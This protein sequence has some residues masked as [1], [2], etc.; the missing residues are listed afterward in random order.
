[1]TFSEVKQQILNLGFETAED[2]E[3]E[4]TILTDALNLAMRQITNLFP[5]IGSYAIRQEPVAAGEP[6]YLRYDF[7]E[8]TR[9]AD[10]TAVF[11][12]FLELVTEDGEYKKTR[13]FTVEQRHVLVLDGLKKING[14]VFYK[15][16]FTPFTPQTAGDRKIK[17][18]YDKEFLLPLLAAW[19]VWRD[20]ERSKASECK[21]E[22]EDGVE[23]L[24]SVAKPDTAEEKFINSL[25]W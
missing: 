24:L 9:G 12:D 16:N 20:D 4:A 6:R 21:N 14:T 17:L 19:Y 8:L 18:D 1:M 23:R 7:E 5:L 15:K 3:E 2:Y 13:N 25:G 22:Y 11:I 10:G